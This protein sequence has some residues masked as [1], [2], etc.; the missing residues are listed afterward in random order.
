M[1]LIPD[2]PVSP[3]VFIEEVVPQAFAQDSARYAQHLG[4]FTFGQPLTGR[5]ATLDNLA[6]QNL[7]HL[8]TNR[9]R[10]A[11]QGQFAIHPATLPRIAGGHHCR[12][13]YRP[14]Q[15]VDSARSTVRQRR[16]G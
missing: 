5:K 7:Q 6:A 11:L 9:G 10:R 8:F 3:K 2:A 16:C 4:Q 1:S 12:T 15:S 13:S 14:P